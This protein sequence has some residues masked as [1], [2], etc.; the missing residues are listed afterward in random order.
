MAQW[1]NDSACLCG[2][3]SSIPGLVQWV[4]D[5]ALMQLWCRLKLGLRFDPWP[6]IGLNW[7]NTIY[8]QAPLELSFA[9]HPSN[10]FLTKL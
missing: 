3:A 7:N 4:K 6:I 9:R 8:Q 2:D 10:E 5:L 1:V